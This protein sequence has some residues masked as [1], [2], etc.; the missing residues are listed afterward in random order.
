M[1]LKFCIHKEQMTVV[2]S[3]FGEVS[4]EAI[5]QSLNYIWNLPEFNS[6]YNGIADFREAKLLFSKNDLYEII[7][8]VAEDQ[9]SLR[10][11]VAILVSEPFAAAMATI[12]G[13][14]S[15]NIERV[16]IFCYTLEATKYLGVDPN[17]MNCL[18]EVEVVQFK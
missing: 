10:G 16:E 7:N 4:L 15:V 13:Q 18:N 17:I 2:R 1:E 9:K 8:K 6:N 5:K 12:Y 11:K 3:F 14:H